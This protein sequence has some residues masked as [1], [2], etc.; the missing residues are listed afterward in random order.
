MLN[1]TGGFQLSLGL[2]QPALQNGDGLRVN[3]EEGDSGAEIRLD[4]NDFGF[5]LK[6]IV[7]G[8]DFDQDEGT[9]GKGI[10]HVQVAAVK[11]ELADTGGD[12]D[13]GLLLDELRAGDKGVAWRAALFD[14][15]GKPLMGWC[16]EKG[17]SIAK[18]SA[19]FLKLQQAIATSNTKDD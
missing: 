18:S 10:H 19:S 13:F 7:A 9:L 3:F 2:F 12:A 15:Q 11:A 5:G 17:R 1:L 8:E 16:H 14:R 6:E 4:V